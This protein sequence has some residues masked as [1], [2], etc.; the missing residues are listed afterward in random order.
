M[1][2]TVLQQ[3]T[4]KGLSRDDLP[5][6]VNF[7][8]MIFL[9][10]ARTALND[11]YRVRKT[12]ITASTNTYT[13]VWTSDAMPLSS[14]WSVDARVTGHATT[15]MPNDGRSD[16]SGLFYRQSGNAAQSGATTTTVAL[17]P[18]GYGVQFAVSGQSVLVQVKDDGAHSVTWA[19]HVYI[20]EAM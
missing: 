3:L 6:W 2:A 15:N 10:Q 14:A 11:E 16:I 4:N 17:L 5:R 12:L 1:R 9:Q 20:R 18:A 19:A 13:T 8:L 7:E